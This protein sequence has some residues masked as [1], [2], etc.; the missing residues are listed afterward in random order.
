M[1]GG[2]ASAFKDLINDHVFGKS[3]LTADANLYLGLS[4]T[5]PGPT[6]SVITEPSGGS[7][8]RKQT[9]PSDWNSS[10]SQQ[11]TNANDLAMVKA[12]A[13]W[14]WCP[15]AFIIN[16][17]TGGT[18]RGRCAL[19]GTVYDFTAATSDVFT[20]PGHGFADTNKVR[21]FGSSLPTG[22]S[23]DTDYYVRDTSGDTFKL[24]A[25]SGGDAIDITAAGIG[26][27]AKSQAKLIDDTDTASF[28][29]GE[30]KFQM[31]QD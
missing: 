4:L 10:S 3:T 17:S 14:G 11:T 21:L 16:A 23:E 18:F 12:T 5:D 9:S 20:A 30:L 15:W 25:T 22:V 13:D 27:I 29:A 8:A 2:F 28:L 24:A 7:Y 19:V 31:P 1:P 6:G 26:E